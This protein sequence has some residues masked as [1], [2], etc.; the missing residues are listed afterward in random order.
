MV[1]KRTDIPADLEE[2]LNAHFGMAYNEFQEEWRPL[3]A[4][5]TTRKASE[6]DV[7]EVGLGV[8]QELGEGDPVAYQQGGQGWKARYIVRKIALAFAITEE[9][10][11]D[12]LYQRTGPKYSRGL[13]RA[14]KEAREIYHARVF[15]NAFDAN[16]KGGDGKP[17]C[18]SDHPLWHGGT[19]SNVLATP[20]NPSESALEDITIMIRRMVDD[21]G[22][23]ISHKPKRII[24]AP[25]QE[26]DWM[27]ILRTTARPGTA[28]NDINA[29][30]A[31]GVYGSEPHILTRL[32]NHAAWFV[33]TDVPDGLKH[34]TRRKVRRGT[35]GDF[36]TSNMKYRADE[37]FT[38]GW[39]DPRCLYGTP[40]ITA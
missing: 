36:E 1:M 3:F 21:R 10:I 30:K 23:P 24:C 26:Y 9:A 25:E 40:G 5:E 31:K 16:Y 29:I 34:F 28:D 38:E 13:A 27:R 33:Q 12:N 2:G 37:R 4:M 11:E 6:E 14:L 15:N 35:T 18:A 17:L 39:S 8:A 20:A 22:L 19:L 7:L 32:T